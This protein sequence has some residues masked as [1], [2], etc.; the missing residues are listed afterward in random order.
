ML[1]AF[2]SIQ[3]LLCFCVPYVV[4]WIW[5]EVNLCTF[6]AFGSNHTEQM[7]QRTE[8][9]AKYTH[10]QRNCQRNNV[11]KMIYSVVYV[12]IIESKD[13]RFGYM[14][15]RNTVLL[16]CVCVTICLNRIYASF[17]MQT[18]IIFHLISSIIR[19]TRGLSLSF[20]GFSYSNTLLLQRKFKFAFWF[21]ISR[22]KIFSIGIECKQLEENITFSIKNKNSHLPWK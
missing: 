8:P 4:W 18:R 15:R 6:S 1:F 19:E 21:K 14:H 2:G 9:S 11:F 12:N 17:T 10:K 7:N 3:L 13:Q 20:V 5:G 22:M 16:L